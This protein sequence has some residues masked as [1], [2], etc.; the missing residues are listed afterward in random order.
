V[1]SINRWKK[2]G[3]K[4]FQEPPNGYAPDAAFVR[5]HC[6]SF[7]SA[8]ASFWP[9]IES[10]RGMLVRYE[11]LLAEAIGVVRR[12]QQKF[13]LVARGNV[14]ADVERTVAPT[15]GI[16]DAPFYRSFYQNRYYLTVLDSDALAAVTETI[17]WELMCL[18]GY[19]RVSATHREASIAQTR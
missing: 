3:L 8:Y 19:P 17:D 16:S 10:G 1:L 11:D 13:G 4:G 9:L 2:N 5:E 6:L 14:L 15:I 12:I 18:Y 7:N